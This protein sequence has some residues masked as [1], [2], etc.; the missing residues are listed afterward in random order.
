MTRHAKR[1]PCARPQWPAPEGWMRTA[2][3]GGSRGGQ[4]RQPLKPPE[5]KRKKAPCG[6]EVAVPQ[7]GI[8]PIFPHGFKATMVD[9]H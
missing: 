9:N 8:E 7:P 3:K 4:R 2:A 1:T 5:G 6:S